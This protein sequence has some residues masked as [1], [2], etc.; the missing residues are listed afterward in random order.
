MIYNKELTLNSLLAKHQ[1]GNRDWGKIVPSS[2]NRNE[3]RHIIIHPFREG[4]QRIKE[5]FHFLIVRAEKL[6]HRR[7]QY[8]K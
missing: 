3:L 4:N 7:L 5:S 6:F 2:H 8:H 1:N